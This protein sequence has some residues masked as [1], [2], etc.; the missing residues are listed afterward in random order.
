MAHSL[1][2]QVSDSI[3]GI[4]NEVGRLLDL[5]PMLKEAGNDEL[6]AK[7]GMQAH[8]LLEVAVALRM[9]LAD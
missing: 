9:A 4:E 6:A 1:Q 3:R 8:K 5:V 2:Y 7:V